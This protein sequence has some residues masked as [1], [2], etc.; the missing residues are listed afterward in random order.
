[1]TSYLM[2]E[3]IEVHNPNCSGVLQIVLYL[4][5]QVI[6]VHNPNC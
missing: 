2:G 3:V 1:M 4:M 5:G 6:G